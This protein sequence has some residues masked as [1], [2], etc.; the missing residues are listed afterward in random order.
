MKMQG[1]RSVGSNQRGDTLRRHPAPRCRQ[2]RSD[3]PAEEEETGVS[4]EC[5]AKINTRWRSLSIV[6]FCASN[7]NGRNGGMRGGSNASRSRDCASKGF[8]RVEKNRDRPF[9]DKLDRHHG[10]EDAAGDG[11]AEAAKGFAEGFVEGFGLLGRSGGDEA[12]AALASGV[13]VESELRN[14]EG[15][16]LCIQQGAIHFAVVVLEDAQVGAFFGQGCSGRGR[17]IA[18]DAEQNHQAGADFSG[19]AAFDGYAG[20]AYALQDGSH[21]V[22]ARLRGPIA[23]A[24]RGILGTIRWPIL[25]AN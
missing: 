9:V 19:D 1:I 23:R 11:D 7:S 25:P 5:T 24:G 12:G 20:A 10:L 14:D 6:K 4:R 13:T 17:I 2:T 22:F 21:G 15:G 16:A 8:V 3:G 18:T